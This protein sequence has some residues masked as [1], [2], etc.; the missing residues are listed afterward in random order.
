MESIGPI[1]PI[2]PEPGGAA[3]GGKL[4]NPSTRRAPALFAYSS[5]QS[6]RFLARL[7]AV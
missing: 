3:D 7:A 5:H 4:Q 2:V 6:T 1:G